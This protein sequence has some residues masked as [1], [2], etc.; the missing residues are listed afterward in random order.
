MLRC[1]DN[2]ARSAGAGCPRQADAFNIVHLHC[3]SAAWRAAGFLA[4]HRRV[5]G[6][7]QI[8]WHGLKKDLKDL[9]VK[10]T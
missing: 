5:A 10:S 9:G 1:R 7:P 8:R 4:G 3:V 2:F 6:T